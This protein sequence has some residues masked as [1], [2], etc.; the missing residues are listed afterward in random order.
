MDKKEKSWGDTNGQ[1]GGVEGSTSREARE[2][3]EWER[4][5]RVTGT[6]CPPPPHAPLSTWASICRGGRGPGTPA[7]WGEGGAG[8]LPREGLPP[9]PPRS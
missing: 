5:K 9:T 2:K 8:V 3:H 4:I 7:S 1:R 6:R